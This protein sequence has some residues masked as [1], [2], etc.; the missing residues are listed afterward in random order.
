MPVTPA[1]GSIKRSRCLHK[2]LGCDPRPPLRRPATGKSKY[3]YVLAETV[4]ILY[5]YSLTSLLFNFRNSLTPK[6]SLISDI[7][8]A[9]AWEISQDIWSILGPYKWRWQQVNCVS[10]DTLGH[11]GCWAALKYKLIDMD[12]PSRHGGRSTMER[13]DEE[14]MEQPRSVR[15]LKIRTRPLLCEVQCQMKLVCE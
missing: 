1:Q 8:H 13:E 14:Q 5:F 6:Q 9:R 11:R 10:L 12:Q 7:I 3:T 4:I 2:K 15:R